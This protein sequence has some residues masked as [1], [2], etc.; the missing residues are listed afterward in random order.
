MRRWIFASATSSGSSAGGFRRT[1][2]M[3]RS[4]HGEF[5]ELDRF[6][7]LHTA[8]DALGRVKEDVGLG[9]EGIAQDADTDAVDDKIPAAEVTEG[10]GIA[11]GRDRGHGL[12][13]GY[14][15]A[16]QARRGG[17]GGSRLPE[18][19]AGGVLDLSDLALRLA[20]HHPGGVLAIAGFKRIDEIDQ[21]VGGSFGRKGARGT[22]RHVTET[23]PAPC[24]VG[25]LGIIEKT[26]RLGYTIAENEGLVFLLD[27][28]RLNLLGEPLI[29][30]DDG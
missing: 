6:E 18:I 25:K 9:G 16:E 22:G 23:A 10:D 13:F 12:G 8:A 21:R 24:L 19:I 1:A 20:V 17:S 2:G 7:I 27:K 26:A 4:V 15:I 28:G 14:G 11:V 29:D 5:H 3:I 30:V